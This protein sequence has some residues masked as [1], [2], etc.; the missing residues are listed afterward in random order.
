MLYGKSFMLPPV[1]RNNAIDL[2]DYT[3]GN[4]VATSLDC[5]V[6]HQL[7]V[8]GYNTSLIDMGADL[9]PSYL[10]RYLVVF[11]ERDVQVPSMEDYH[12]DATL[13][14]LLQYRHMLRSKSFDALE[15]FFLAIVLDHSLADAVLQSISY[16]AFP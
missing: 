5:I 11:R 16:K 1:F 15:K 3:L 8:H 13:S 6:V 14:D 2:I 9:L 4:I 7:H 10:A 12:N